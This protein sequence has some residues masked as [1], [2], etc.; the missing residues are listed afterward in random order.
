MVTPASRATQRHTPMFQSSPGLHGSGGT[1][2]QANPCEAEAPPVVVALSPGTDPPKLWL[3]LPGAAVESFDPSRVFPPQALK[4]NA[5]A[6]G[7]N[8]KPRWRRDSMWRRQHHPCQRRERGY[9]DPRPRSAPICATAVPT[10]AGRP[11]HVGRGQNPRSI[12]ATTWAALGASVWASV[13]TR[14]YSPSPR[15]G[16]RLVRSFVHP[17][18]GR[19]HAS[20]CV[21][22]R[23]KN[24]SKTVRRRQPLSITT[25]EDG[26]RGAPPLPRQGLGT[27]A[28]EGRR[29]STAR[30]S[31]D[32]NVTRCARP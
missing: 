18:V 29:T 20:T 24:E 10:C 19:P 14:R 4:R 30:I 27:Y 13:T 31:I 6:S 7:P 12:F 17:D 28:F 21:R 5:R 8:S 32:P 1:G 11:S 22:P 26:L 23:V 16:W 9:D 2:G 3:P 15:L 25:A